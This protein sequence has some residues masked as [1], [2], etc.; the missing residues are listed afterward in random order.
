MY[1]KKAW[2]QLHKNTA[3]NIKQVLKAAPTKQ[4]LY[5][6]LTPIMKTIQARWSRHAGYCWRSRGEFISEVWTPSHAQAKAGR[7][8]KTYIQ[9][10]YADTECSLE[11][12]PE[13]MD[14]REEWQERVR[15]IRADGATW[16]WQSLVWSMCNWDLLTCF[17]L[18]ILKVGPKVGL[19]K[20]SLLY[21]LL[22]HC[23]CCHFL[24][25]NQL[26]FGFKSEY[27]ILNLSRLIWLLWT[28]R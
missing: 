13:A 22:F 6:H 11:D 28:L 19:I 21:M 17:F 5:S 1:G 7:L 16:W 26:V 8:A 15:D 12:P 23:C 3:N 18:D 4:Q 10:L 24:W 9:K 27:E 14:D 25:R 2:Q 20:K